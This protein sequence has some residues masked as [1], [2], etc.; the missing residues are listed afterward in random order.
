MRMYEINQNIENNQYELCSYEIKGPTIEGLK[1]M[2]KLP[3]YMVALATSFGAVTT[4]TLSCQIIRTGLNC[5]FIYIKNRPKLL[6]IMRIA[7]ILNYN[8]NKPQLS[9]S[10]MFKTTKLLYIPVSERIWYI[11]KTKT[12][13]YLRIQ[14]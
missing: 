6:I 10:F 9:T 1:I 14:Q 5:H 4:S 11:H 8:K 13:M 7:S 3:E 12:S 2:G